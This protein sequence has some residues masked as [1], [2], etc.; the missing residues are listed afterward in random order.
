MEDLLTALRILTV[1]TAVFFLASSAQAHSTAGRIKVPLEKERLEVDDLAYFVEPYVNQEKY[2]DQYERF[3][4]RFAVKEFDRVVQHGS[5]AEVFFT[6]LD[7][8]EKNRTF[9]DSMVFER[10][11][12]GLWVYAGKEGDRQAVYTY[13]DKTRYYIEKYASGVSAVGL[14]LFI[15][16]LLVLRR[17]RRGRGRPKGPKNGRGTDS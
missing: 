7:F 3:K 5:R 9:P 12:D 11:E 8:K 6:V 16:L 14:V 1:V 13:V 10:G 2:R 4:N 17:S 15:S